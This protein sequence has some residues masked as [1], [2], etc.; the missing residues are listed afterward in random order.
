MLN[1]KHALFHHKYPSCLH[2][3]LIELVHKIRQVLLRLIL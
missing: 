3:R 1:E 2:G